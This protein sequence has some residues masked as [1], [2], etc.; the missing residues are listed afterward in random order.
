MGAE[1]KGHPDIEAAQHLLGVEEVCTK[2]TSKLRA[3]GVL[4]PDTT[5]ALAGYVNTVHDR[6][7]AMNPNPTTK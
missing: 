4:R 5:P 6:P 2:I 1:G 7:I 3:V